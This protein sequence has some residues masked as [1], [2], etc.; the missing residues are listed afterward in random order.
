MNIAFVRIADK[1]PSINLA[2]AVGKPGQHAG[3]VPVCYVQVESKRN[4][5]TA[6]LMGFA[7]A[8]IPERAAIRKEIHVVDELPLTSVGKVLKPQLEMQE[9]EKCIASIA[10]K[11]L[12]GKD[13]QIEVKQDPK[14]GILAHVNLKDCDDSVKNGFAKKL[15]E[16]T[17]KSVCV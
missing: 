16:Y 12:S 3:E 6:S 7:N 15:G 10:K 17:F 2:A 13:V 4:I 11:D 5:D 14:H 8:E 9:I 1:H